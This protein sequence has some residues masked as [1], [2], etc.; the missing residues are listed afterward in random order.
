MAMAAALYVCVRILL[1]IF[2][3]SQISYFVKYLFQFQILISN[4]LKYLYAHVAVIWREN[5]KMAGNRC[6]LHV[7]DL[8]RETP[9]SVRRR[10]MHH[11]ISLLSVRRCTLSSS[12]S[13]TLSRQKLILSS[14]SPSNRTTMQMQPSPFPPASVSSSTHMT[15]L[16]TSWHADRPI[17][18]LSHCRIK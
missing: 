8:W 3:I 2:L 12:L 9:L 10:P 1:S 14:P 11:T 16:G 15:K 6:S 5:R 17:L 4:L 18:A 7:A 13:V